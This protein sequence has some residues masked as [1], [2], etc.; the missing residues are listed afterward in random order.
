MTSDADGDSS[1]NI[2]GKMCQ[3]DSDWFVWQV[4]DEAWT[5]LD[6]EVTLSQLDADLDL[7]VCFKCYVGSPSFSCP[8]G[9]KG[10]TDG[11]DCCS[12]VKGGTTTETIEADPSCPSQAEDNMKVYIKVVP[13]YNC[14]GNE[15]Y[16]LSG[17]F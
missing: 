2:T 14:T 15:T 9:K 10:A 5:T 6:P 16:K 8:V 11:L 1:F 4:E 7:W 17:H 3:N 12:N 13:D